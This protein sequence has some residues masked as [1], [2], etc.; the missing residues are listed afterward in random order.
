MIWRILSRRGFV[1]PLPHKRP[2]SAW[3]RFCAEQPNELCQADVTHWRL[4]DNT[5]VEILNIF[6]GFENVQ[7]TI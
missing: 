3:I 1:I 7:A 6:V 2:R 5:E 4:A